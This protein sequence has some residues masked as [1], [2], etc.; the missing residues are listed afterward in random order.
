MK[1]LLIAY[2]FP[3]L[4]DPQ[5]LRWYYLS[6]ALSEL[7][8]EIDVLTVQHPEKQAW[9][10]HKNIRIF[11]IFPGPV[12][13]IALRAKWDMGVE[14]NGNEKIRRSARFKIL[15]SLYWGARKLGGH[16]LPGD[17]RTEW[18]P[19]VLR[20]IAKYIELKKYH[21]ILTSHE[22][23]VD[24]LL[25]LYLKVKHPKIKWIADF[26]DP[27]VALYT[28]RHKLFF[29]N[30]F[31]KSIYE[32]AD[33]LIFTHPQVVHHL[34]R[35]Y[36]F[37]RDKKIV[38]IAQGFSYGLSREGKHVESRNK[39]FTMTYA[40]TFY[41]D[42]RNP[43]NLIQALSK[44]EFDYRFLLIG[45]NEGFLKDFEA[46]GEKCEFLGYMDHFKVLHLERESDVLIHLSNR[47]GVQI[48]GK[49]YEYL[50]SRRPILCI[51]NNTLD[52]TGDLIKDLKMGIATPDHP[53]EIKQ[54]I[55][56]LYRG[57]K[58]EKGRV[59]ISF[60]KLY[61]YSWEKKAGVL[62]ENLREAWNSSSIRGF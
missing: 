55:E 60:E 17:I 5:S 39:I 38:L 31:E 27:Y 26:G 29:E 44:L 24:S 50:G 13:Y 51:T 41:R 4:Q 8:M 33:M 42:F 59:D 7:G 37:I 47:N 18:F 3:P 40:G 19:L 28:P 56:R 30:R 43:S 9:P 2:S 48:P 54:A 36:P 52:K 45:R 58:K 61:D 25:G 35:K 1:I 20:Y 16:V 49:I 22:P 62:Y 6:N 23:W 12:E 14:A 21:Y 15:K 10:F 57:W 11:R 32:K 34:D 53:D 46:I